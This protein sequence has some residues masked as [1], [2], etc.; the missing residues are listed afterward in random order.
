M[1]DD[2]IIEVLRNIESEKNPVGFNMNW[3][4]HA[5][6][7]VNVCHTTACLAGHA[8]INEGYT[9]DFKNEQFFTQTGIAVDAQEEGA[10]ILGITD[11]EGETLFY[12]DNIDEVYAWFAHRMGIEEQVLRDKV[13]G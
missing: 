10:K 4:A 9:V 3:W 2:K 6:E 12:L 5:G 11:W 1:N 7:G 8:L 13:M